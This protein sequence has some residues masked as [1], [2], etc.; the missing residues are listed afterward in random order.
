MHSHAFAENVKCIC[1][2]VWAS[3]AERMLSSSQKP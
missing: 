2:N 3:L 1:A